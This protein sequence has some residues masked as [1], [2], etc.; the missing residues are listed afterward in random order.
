MNEI[1]LKSY[2][3]INIFLHILGKRPDGFHELYTLF[4]RISLHDTLIIKKSDT[5]RIICD[6]PSIPVDETNIISLV[7]RILEED[8][9]ITDRFE[10]VLIK[11]IPDGGGLGGGS[12]NAAAYLEGVL[13]LLDIPM[14]MQTKT[15]I[16]AK[17][18][19]DTA[20]FLHDT[21]MI[22]EGRGEILT[23]YGDLPEFYLVIANP[24]VHVPTGKVFLSGNLKLTQIAEVNRMRHAADYDD[25]GEILFNG[26]EEAVFDMYPAVKN[27]KAALLDAGADFAL[28]SGSGASVFGIFK[29]R[30]SAESAQGIIKN[31]NPAWGVF[32]AEPV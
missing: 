8:H 9:G 32:T 7:Q 3:K 29:D 15:D 17:V 2:G 18:G 28:M 19:S 31:N 6:K 21:P 25:L 12:S 24:G 4:S 11:R 30:Q 10:T 14:D 13:Q 27:A 26:M 23:P 5:H 16:M 22:G 1:S 20:F